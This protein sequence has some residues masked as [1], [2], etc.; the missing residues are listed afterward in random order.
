[1]E[2]G[3]AIQASE[4]LYKAAEEAVKALAQKLWVPEAAE[5]RE[6]GGGSPGS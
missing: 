4:K 5:A 2:R 3:D 1:V 6:Y